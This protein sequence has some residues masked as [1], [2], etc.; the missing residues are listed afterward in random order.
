MN[1]GWVDISAVSGQQLGKRV[2]AATDMNA[3][4]QELFSMWSMLRCYKQ[5]TRSVDSI[6]GKAVKRE[7][8]LKV[9][10]WP[11]LEPLPGNV[12]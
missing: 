4:M 6:L 12:K 10:E 5:G 1:G 8:E 2:S 7:L 11:L 3:T 9:E